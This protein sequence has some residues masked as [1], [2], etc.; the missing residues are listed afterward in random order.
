M[1]N[2]I[3]CSSVHK[4]EI[5]KDRNSRLI[6]TRKIFLFLAFISTIRKNFAKQKVKQ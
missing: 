6:K 4:S 1:R 3:A 2:K 5:L